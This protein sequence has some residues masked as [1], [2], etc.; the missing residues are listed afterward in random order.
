MAQRAREYMREI[1]PDVVHAM[2]FQGLS[3]SVI[4]VF[5]EFDVPLVFTAEDFWTVCPVVDLRRHDGLMRTGPEVTHCV[6]CIASRKPD[7]RVRNAAN[8]VP[9]PRSEEGR[10][11]KECR[12]RW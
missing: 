8:L 9:G 6:R 11:R 4:P 12:S 7:P 2:H 5:K 1:D 10:V 3:T